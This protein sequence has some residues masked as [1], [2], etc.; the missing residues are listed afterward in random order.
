MKRLVLSLILALA[1]AST[2]SAQG[3]DLKGMLGSLV[4]SDKITVDKMGGNWAYTAPAVSFKSSNVLKKAGGA[5]ASS[6]VEGK[7]APYFKKARLDKLTVTVNAADSTFAMSL[8]KTTLKGTIQ[9]V[10]DTDSDANFIFNFKVG[11]KIP[12]GKIDTYVTM[13]GNDTMSLMFDVSK[14]VTIIEKVS[15][16]TG[17]STIASVTKLLKGYDGICAGFK[18]KRTK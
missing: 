16:V 1:L 3:F 5:A 10:T 15:S 11:G 12:A 18:L 4:S 17:N 7:L 6:T 8:G 9:A 13:T 14:L 2:A